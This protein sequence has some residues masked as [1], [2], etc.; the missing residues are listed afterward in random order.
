MRLLI[1]TT[2]RSFLAANAPTADTITRAFQAARI[3]G[4]DGSRWVGSSPR[5]TRRAAP[6]YFYTTASWVYE[7]PDAIRVVPRQAL[8]DSVARQ[9]RAQSEDWDPP[10]AYAYDPNVHG[11]LEWWRSGQAGVTRSRDEAPTEFGRLD[12]SENPTGPTTRETHP[13]T[14]AET[15]RDV[16]GA[17]KHAASGASEAGASV[18]LPVVATVG[19]GALVVG[20]F[21]WIASAQAMRRVLPEPNPDAETRSMKSRNG[22]KTV[23]AA[24]HAMRRGKV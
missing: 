21:Y 10:T 7:W 19:A 11:S 23:A 2:E 16:A 20:V 8:L 17:V 15:A 6:P 24:V 5:I 9:L 14:A 13:S 4:N 12:A 18:L 3:G 1:T 22:S